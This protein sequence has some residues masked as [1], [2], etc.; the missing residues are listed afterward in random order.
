MDQTESECVYD[1][2]S[3]VASYVWSFGD[4]TTGSGATTHHAFSAGGV[5]VVTLTAIDEF[6]RSAWT[7]QAVEV[8]TGGRPTSVFSFLP[9]TP[10]LGEATFFNAAESTAPD[11]RSFFV[12]GLLETLRWQWSVQSPTSILREGTYSVGSTVTDD[13]GSASTATVSV[14][15]N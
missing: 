15:V 5:K 13:S 10:N 8:D 11:G 7:A 14:V 4:R 9:N 3:Q 6:G 12:T 2:Q 1:P